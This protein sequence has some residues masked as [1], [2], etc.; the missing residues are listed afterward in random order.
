VEKT[1]EVVEMRVGDIQRNFGNPRK[2]SKKKRAELA[3]SME[4][5]G[6]FGIFVIDEEDNIIAGNQ[7]LEILAERDQ[8]TMVLCKRLI[9]YT[10]AEKRAINVRDNTHA[11]EWDL[12]MLSDWMADISLDLGVDLDNDD[13]QEMMPPDM[14][15]KAFEHWDYIVFVFSNQSDWLNVCNLF[16]LRKVNAGYGRTKKIGI[17]R[18]IHGARLLE[19]L[20]HSSSHSKQG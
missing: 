15:L 13:I 20:R 19:A 14:E 18:V 6:N 8:D 12:D 17:G 10:V 3:I 1:I 7:R 4:T 5:L 16:E 11:G 2:I 9:G